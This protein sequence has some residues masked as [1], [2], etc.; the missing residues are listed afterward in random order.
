MGKNPDFGVKKLKIGVRE[1]SK[2]GENPKFGRG[3]SSKSGN[4][5]IYSENA[6]IRGLLSPGTRS[7]SGISAPGI[8]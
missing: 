5:K 1:E 8:C 2:N 7:P 4:P 3:R 6:Q